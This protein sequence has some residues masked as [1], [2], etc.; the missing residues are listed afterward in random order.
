MHEFGVENPAELLELSSNGRNKDG[1]RIFKSS[2][3][4]NLAELLEHSSNGEK[5]D[6]RIENIPWVQV[7]VL[8][9]NCLNYPVTE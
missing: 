7:L 5:K 4:F 6:H 1:R 9:P 2:K 8:K 3:K